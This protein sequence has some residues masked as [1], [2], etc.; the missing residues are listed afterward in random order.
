MKGSAV[1][2]RASAFPVCTIGRSPPLGRRVRTTSTRRAPASSAAPP[3]VLSDSPWPAASASARLPAGAGRQSDLH[4]FTLTPRGTAI[5]TS[6]EVRTANL[7]GVGGP[8]SG[9]VIGGIVQE[10]TIPGARVLFAWRSLNHVPIEE[11]HVVFNG[12]AYDYFHVN[13]VDIDADGNLLVS[14][15]NTWTVYKVHRE[16]GEVLWRLGGKRSDFQMGPGTAFAWQHDARHHDEGGLI[17]LFDNGAAPPVAPQSRGIV[18]ALDRRGRRARLVRQYVHPRR[19]LT[20]F[21]G[22]APVLPNGNGVVGG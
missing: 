20:P 1:R 6:Y 3:A 5:V 8:P 13:S 19:L 17:S 18:V 12:H 21:M 16:T 2:V 9:K 15:R 7:S 10:I 11:S 4:E 14:A 22:N